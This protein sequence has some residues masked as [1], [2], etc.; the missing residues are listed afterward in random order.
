[1]H[2]SHAIGRGKSPD[3]RINYN[4]D[5]EIATKG[6]SRTADA[7]KLGRTSLSDGKHGNK[8]ATEAF[9][10]INSVNESMVQPQ[11]M[12]EL[13]VKVKG[14]QRENKELYAKIQENNEEY[15]AVSREYNHIS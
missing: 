13:E 8:F 10:E 12:L 4:S 7:L 6:R 3:F 14:Y 11:N 5:N 1:M 2:I 9:S 15:S